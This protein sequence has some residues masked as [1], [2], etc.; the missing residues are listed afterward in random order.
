MHYL[1][2]ALG[3][4]LMVR[5]IPT[6]MAIEIQEI[7]NFLS[8]AFKGSRMTFSSF[9]KI[10]ELRLFKDELGCKCAMTNTCQ[11]FER[12]TL[13]NCDARGYNLTDESTLSSDQLPVY[14]LQYGGAYTPFSNVKF[15]I[16]PIIYFGKK[17]IIHLKK[18]FLQTKN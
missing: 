16:G 3:L 1:D 2:S 11:T 18:K 10:S 17:D 7:L 6:G 14:G 8:M 5:R 15:N 9:L 12:P 13:C 4:V